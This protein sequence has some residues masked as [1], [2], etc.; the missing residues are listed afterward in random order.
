MGLHFRPDL[1]VICLTLDDAGGG[2][3]HLAFNHSIQGDSGP[4]WRRYYH[5][6][7]RVLGLIESRRA[8]AD[9]IESYERS[10]AVES[11][12]RSRV[13]YALRRARDLGRSSEFQVALMIFPMLWKLSGDYPFQPAHDAVAELAAE[14]EIPLL[15][16]LPA[17]QGFEGP[18]LWVHPSNQHPNEVAHAIAGRA[19][20]DFLHS[21]DLVPD[22]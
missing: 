10:F 13:R 9:L 3:A 20:V 15:D 21:E 1:V 18:E 7:D 17:F 14:L 5:T 16:L 6:A 8:M 11:V 19:L 22:E 2:A 4:A 12:G